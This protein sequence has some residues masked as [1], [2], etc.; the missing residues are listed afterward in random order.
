MELAYADVRVFG[1]GG[2]G[3]ARKDLRHQLEPFLRRPIPVGRG[4]LQAVDAQIVIGRRPIPDVFHEALMEAGRSRN[5]DMLAVFIL[6]DAFK[7][8]FP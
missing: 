2:D 4:M 3:I 1:H 5:V 7:F 8:E 6:A